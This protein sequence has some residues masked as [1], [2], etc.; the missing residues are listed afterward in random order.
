MKVAI[1]LVGIS[2]GNRNRDW[3]NQKENIKL[4]LIDVLS[5]ENSVDIYLTTYPNN[6]I[7][8]LIKFYN[9]KKVN[10]L[11]YENSDQRLTYISSLEQL[12]EEDIDVVV[13]TRF[14]I[15]FKKSYDTF[16]NIDYSKVNFLFM[17]NGWWEKHN[18]VCDNFF[19]FPKKFLKEFITGIRKIYDNPPRLHCTD[20]HSIYSKL[21]ET[22][23]EELVVISPTQQASNDNEFYRLNRI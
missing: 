2:S 14:D 8:D 20:L 4:N 17:E 18:Y 3:R 19:I 12:L 23:H 5:K 16:E 21:K 15:V 11:P 6:T 9:P 10:I 13:S 22:M 7:E 1:N